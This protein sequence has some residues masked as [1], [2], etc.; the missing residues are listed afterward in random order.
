MVRT[1]RKSRTGENGSRVFR[2]RTEDPEK[3]FSEVRGPHRQSA[4]R[5]EKFVPPS[6]H[7]FRHQNMVVSIGLHESFMS[8][9]GNMSFNDSSDTIGLVEVDQPSAQHHSKAGLKHDDTKPFETILEN[10]IS[11]QGSSQKLIDVRSTTADS[12]FPVSPSRS[13]GSRTTS[14]MRQER[15]RRTTTRSMPISSNHSEPPSRT[16]REDSGEDQMLQQPSNFYGPKSQMR[17]HCQSSDRAHPTHLS[18]IPCSSPIRRAR[19]NYLGSSTP[20]LSP[21][22]TRHETSS[23]QRSPL[24]RVNSTPTSPGPQS[25]SPLRH[26]GTTSSPHPVRSGRTYHNHLNLSPNPQTPESGTNRTRVLRYPSFGGSEAYSM[27]GLGTSVNNDG[28]CCLTPSARTA[29]T[30]PI[31]PQSQF[32]YL[33]PQQLLHDP[34]ADESFNDDSLDAQVALENQEYELIKFALGLSLAESR[35]HGE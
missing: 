12:C 18:P 30:Q 9:L 35:P 16:S 17:K 11:E 28:L 10:N 26:H 25:S 22:V 31:T 4:T 7:D 20:R 15:Q 2:S 33:Q 6:Q 32:S 14:S 8:S 29:S 3:R 13:K 23:I 1:F 27:Y 34:N 5:R 21:F 24:R 19:S